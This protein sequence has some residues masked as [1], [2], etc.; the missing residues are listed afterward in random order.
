[1]KQLVLFIIIA[2]L[3]GCYGAEPEKTGLEGKPL[4]SF[5]LLLSDSSTYIDMKDIPKGKPVVL[6]YYGPY[7][8]YSRA[9]MEEI[10]RDIKQFKNTQFYV[11]TAWPFAD[12][13]KFYSY[14]RLDKYKNII[15]G[16]DN[17]GFFEEYYKVAGVPFTAVYD[18]DG[19][20]NKAFQGKIH[21][22]EIIKA[23]EL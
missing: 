2:V 15:A 4:P 14:Y 19:K 6:F 5:K 23:L 8:P 18:K 20:L 10:I 17:S 12:M 1:M 7:C 13:K 16:L 9:Q 11:F 3:S 21:S 22:K